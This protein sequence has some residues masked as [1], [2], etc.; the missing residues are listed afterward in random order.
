M[1]TANEFRFGQIW[2][3]A[4]G[5]I[6]EV[7]KVKN[8]R[9]YLYCEKNQRELQRPSGMVSGLTLIKRGWSDQKDG[10]RDH[11]KIN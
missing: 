5:L 9:A 8:K 6:W 7:N 3:D 2:Q 4:S 10:K 11:G 1:I